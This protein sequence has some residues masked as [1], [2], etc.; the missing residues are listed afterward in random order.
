MKITCIYS[1]STPAI[2]HCL[3]EM[4]HIIPKDLEDRDRITAL[5]TCANFDVFLDI[6][7][8]NVMYRFGIIV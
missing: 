5:I 2:K 4:C 7:M 8:F 1:Y 3:D 6:G